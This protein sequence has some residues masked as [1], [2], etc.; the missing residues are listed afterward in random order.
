M[1]PPKETRCAEGRGRPE[2]EPRENA[3]VRTQRRVTLPAKL[4]RV[5]EAARRDKSTRFTALLHHVDVSV[6][7]RAF[8]RL[9]RNAAP[10]V[11]GETAASYEVDLAQNLQRLH[12][13]IHSGRYRPQ[14][15]R[16]VYIPKPDGGQRPLGVT[17][18]EDKIVQG[19][20][21]EV[22][23]AIY[24]VDF[25]GFSYGFR[26]GRSPH[27]ALEALHT[28]F[29]TQYVNWVLDADVRSFFSS[30]DHEWLLRMVA[31]RIADRRILRLIRGWL[32][33][34]VME[35]QRWSET[36]QGTSQGSGISPLLANIFMHYALDLWVHQWR[37]RYARGRVI[38]V[39]YCDDFVMGFQYEADARRML[40]DLKERLAK[41]KL[42]LHEQKTRLIEF[43]KLSSELRRRRGAHRCETFGFL[44][45]THYC[46]RSRDG[47]FVVK[48]RTDRQRL[49]RKLKEL[50]SEARRR[51]HTPIVLQYRWLCSVLRGH[52]AYFGLPS[53]WD[54]LNAF[55]HETR[56]IWYSALNRRSQRR[57]SWER[58]VRLLERFPLPTPTVTHPRPVVAC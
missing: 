37:Q 15:V 39:R 6:L 54:R 43:G 32:R 23:S 30:V 1:M 44:G 35:G 49:T 18:L 45:F 14:P 16:R 34:G 13:Q 25:L 22:L 19:A 51:M 5:N 56:R 53:N 36:V 42:A 4:A 29:M 52:F 48:R 41:F 26:P 8:G 17:A 11:D 55:S 7:E 50:R 40:V 21:A 33:A 31:H 10:G 46:A 47:R 9:K 24:E 3:R 12:A 58:Y 20:V 2:A 28:A 27:Q 38:I 57:L